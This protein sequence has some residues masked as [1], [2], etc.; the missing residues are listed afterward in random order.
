MKYMIMMFGD[1]ATMLEERP[2]EWVTEM[3]GFMTQ[4]DVDLREAGE[5]IDAQ[6]LADASQARV[7]RRTDDGPVVTDG[8]YAESKESLIGYWVLDVADEDRLME[9]CASIVHYSE[10][11]EVRPVMEPPQV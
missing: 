2:K 1:A 8:P 4:L 11:V 9:I 7:V 5:L 10:Q 6:G 3:I